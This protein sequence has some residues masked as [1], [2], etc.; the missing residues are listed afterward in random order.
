MTGPVRRVGDTGLLVDCADPLEAA[1]L[2][3]RLRSASG[4]E[5]LPELVDV[6][7]AARTVLVTAAP[8]ALDPVTVQAWLRGAADH[9]APAPGADDALPALALPVRFDGPDLGSTAELVGTDVDGL[10]DRVCAAV[11][12]VAFTGFTPGF[13]YCVGGGLD[14]PRLDTPR[15]RVPARSVGLAGPYAGV[16]PRASPGGWRLVGTLTDDV[17]ELF[18]ADRDPPALLAPGREV[19]FEVGR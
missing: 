12:T 10:V 17:P 18:A 4:G 14:V 6:V 13:G 16:Y 2:A 9:P 5:V 8:G 11:W 3:D 19:R 15:T 1:S 7:P